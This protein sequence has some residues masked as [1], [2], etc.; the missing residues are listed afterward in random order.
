MAKQKTTNAQM[1]FDQNASS[2]GY[3]KIGGV[4]VQWGENAAS[5]SGT[6]ITFPVSFSVAPKVMVN[7]NDPGN[8]D[9]RAYS[10]STTGC[11]LRQNYTTNPLAIQWLAIGVA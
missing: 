2:A 11:T 6:A 10:I 1:N 8:Q 4:L 9:P 7:L 5:S 3:I